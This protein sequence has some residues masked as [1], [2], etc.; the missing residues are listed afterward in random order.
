MHDFFLFSSYLSLKLACI[1]CDEFLCLYGHNVMMM[2][3][4]FANII[5]F[6]LIKCCLGLMFMLFTS[7]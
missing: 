1:A 4:K 3:W 5:L 6:K 7:A 2:N